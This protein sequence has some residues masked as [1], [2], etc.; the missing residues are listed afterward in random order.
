MDPYIALT[1]PG[2]VSFHSEGRELAVKAYALTAA[3]A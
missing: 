2:R 3:V 1:Q